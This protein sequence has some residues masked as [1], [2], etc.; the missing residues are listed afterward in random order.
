MIGI[1]FAFVVVLLIVF[2]VALFIGGHHYEP[3]NKETS[4]DM[5]VTKE[6][7]KERFKWNS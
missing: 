7:F 5:D 3:M 6:V 4:D 2:V 1:L